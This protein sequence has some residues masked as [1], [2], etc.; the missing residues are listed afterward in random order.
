[1][2]TLIGM[3]GGVDSAVTAALVSRET[4]AAGITL[5]LYDGGNTD[6]IE[7]FN[8][9]AG[10]AADVC[11]KLGITHTVLNLKSEFN[12]FVIKYFI[13]EYI[14]GRTPNPCIQ[15]N[16]NIKFGAMLQYAQNNGFDKI[17]TGHYARIEKCGDKYLLKKASDHTKDQ[18]YVLYGLTEDQLSKTVLPL[19]DYTKRQA[20][21][22][23]EDLKLCVARKSDSQDI[24]FVPDGDYAAFIERNRGLSFAAGD[25]LDLE[26]NILGKHKGVIHYTIG[27]RKGLGIALGKHAFV[28]NKNADTNQVVLGDEEHLFYNIIEVSNVNIIAA[29][30]LDG[31]KAAGKLRYRHT[32]QPCV[33]HQTGKD[34]V[35]LEFDTPQRAPSPGQAAVF[36][37]GDI[38]LGGGT[39][40]KGIK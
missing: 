18:S 22:I 4:S 36:Y 39:I 20:R 23:A 2:K 17:A 11:K 40:V 30:S 29:D 7:K 8:R 28:L 21:E 16:I 3:S 19:G 10:D 27:Q 6:L 5:Q 1:M 33:I 9:E 26:G 13:D 34:T 24:C 38:V 31:I 35:I 12:D 14:A 37:D 32:E 15:C 25:Y